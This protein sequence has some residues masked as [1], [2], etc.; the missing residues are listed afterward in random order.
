[1]TILEI[2]NQFEEQ[3]KTVTD[4]KALGEIRNEYI[5]KKGIVSGLMKQMKDVEDKKAFGQEVNELKTYIAKEIQVLQDKFEAHSRKL[6]IL[7]I[8]F[9]DMFGAR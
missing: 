3:I 4:A 5:S 1:M 8:L 7:H 2:K 9:T 6:M